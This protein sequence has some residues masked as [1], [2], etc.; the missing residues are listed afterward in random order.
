MC[1]HY[2]YFFFSREKPSR[3]SCPSYPIRT[4]GSPEVLHVFLT[5]TLE[6]PPLS[7]VGSPSSG[8]SVFLC[9]GLLSWFYCIYYLAWDCLCAFY[10]TTRTFH[11]FH[12]WGNKCWFCFRLNTK[13]KESI[14]CGVRQFL[15][16]ELGSNLFQDSAS[17]L[18]LITLICIDVNHRAVAKNRREIFI[19]KSKLRL[20]FYQRKEL[21]KVHSI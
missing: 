12:R 10:P 20:S 18:H 13:E 2:Y 7:W 16:P 1:K 11:P 21:H 3:G 15:F 6:F 5:I 17:F 14:Q 4:G 19:S 8:S 9:L